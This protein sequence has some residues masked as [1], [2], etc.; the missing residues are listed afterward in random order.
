M[1][2]A[3]LVLLFSGAAFVLYGIACAFDPTVAAN[4]I[5][6]DL[7]NSQLRIEVIAMYGGLQTALGVIFLYC[8]L[9][10]EWLLPGLSLTAV[11]F[12]CLAVGRTTG[13]ILH[14]SDAYNFPTSIYE[15][16]TALLAIVAI[17]LVRKSAQN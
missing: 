5:G 10:T 6:F 4:I 1:L 13:I 15:S 9:R 17:L 11:C 7:T 8:G 2:L 14:G 12:L 3:R 16:V